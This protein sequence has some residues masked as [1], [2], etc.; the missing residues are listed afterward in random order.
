ML[1]HQ[2][3]RAQ[4]REHRRYLQGHRGQGEGE[5][6]RRRTLSN[7]RAH[8]HEPGTHPAGLLWCGGVPRSPSCAQ[9]QHQCGQHQQHAQD[10]LQLIRQVRGQCLAVRLEHRGCSELQRQ[11]DEE[12]PARHRAQVPQNSARSHC[13]DQQ[14]Q[15]DEQGADRRRIQQRQ[16]E[17]RDEEHHRLSVSV[18]RENPAADIAR[19]WRY[20]G[21]KLRWRWGGRGR[22]EGGHR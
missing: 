17:Q 20:A 9:P 5:H 16:P 3:D 13:G 11:P 1:G 22:P 14:P 21:T 2:S 7:A 15:R 4:I 19:P 18:P 6:R 10:Q 12:I 8:A